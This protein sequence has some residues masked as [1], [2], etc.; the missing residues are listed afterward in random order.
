MNEGWVKAVDL[1]L[2]D[3]VLLYSGEVGN[4]DKVEKEQLDKAV[5]VYNF[6]VEDWHTYFVCEEAVLVHNTCAAPYGHLKDSKYVGKGK[7]F[8]AA[9]KKKIIKENMKKNGGVVRS[10]LSGKNW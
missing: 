8:T 5:K 3:E 6:E 7:S 9:Q 2:G 4:V 10:V 1:D